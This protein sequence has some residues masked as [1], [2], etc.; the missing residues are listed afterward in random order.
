MS[1]LAVVVL[2]GGLDSTTALAL[3]SN[4]YE[5]VHA[6]TFEYGQKHA[7][8]V[9]QAIEIASYYAVDHAIFPLSESLF[10]GG[11]LTTE[12]EIEDMRYDDLL[13]GKMSPTYVPF[14]NGNLISMAVAY[15]DSALRDPENQVPVFET[16]G[17]AAWPATVPVDLQPQWD[18][19]VVL[20]GMH[21]EDAAGFAYADCTPEF[22][23]AMASAVYI[24]TYG[25]VR[26][27]APFQHRTK[28]EIV[29]IGVDLAAPY[30][31]THSC[32]RGERPA[33]GRC[34][35]CYARL[36]AFKTAG[37]DDPLNYQEPVSG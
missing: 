30:G 24:G 8:E 2:S 29:K 20:A 25:R 9:N 23:G 5:S 27:H 33:C 36:E 19:A 21:A 28:A 16:Q 1:T 11:S 18:N 17:D 31:L 15:A 12:E 7:V 34:A 10:K 32:Y 26:F 13:S 6:I 4:E 3:A 35:T 22:L 14:R 37:Y